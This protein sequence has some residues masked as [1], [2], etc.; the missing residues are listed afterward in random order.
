MDGLEQR[1]LEEKIKQQDRILVPMNNRRRQ[2]Q[3]R[4]EDLN[5]SHMKVINGGWNTYGK[6]ITVS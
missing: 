2:V 5:Y 6:P 1:E 3:S 4:N